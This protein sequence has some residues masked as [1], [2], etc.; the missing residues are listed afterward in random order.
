M[1]LPYGLKPELE[2]DHV[3]SKPK[4]IKMCNSLLNSINENKSFKLAMFHR[5]VFLTNI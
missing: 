1:D 2:I 4:M 3:L 5:Y